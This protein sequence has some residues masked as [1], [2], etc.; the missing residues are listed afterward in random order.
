MSA[1]PEEMLKE[2]QAYTT[3]RNT[4]FVADD[5]NLSLTV[6]KAGKKSRDSGKR[7]S[8]PASKRS[9][10]DNSETDSTALVGR[11]DAHSSFISLCLAVGGR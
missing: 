9:R 2:L 5:T 11:F 3:V 4:F 10:E 7:A 8:E 6:M 1:L